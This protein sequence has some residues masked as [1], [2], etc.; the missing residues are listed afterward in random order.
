ME[1]KH[2]MP[3]L[4]FSQ[5]FFVVI[6]CCSLCF[7]LN[8][9]YHNVLLVVFSSDHFIY[10]FLCGAYSLGRALWDLVVKS[11]VAIKWFLCV[12]GGRPQ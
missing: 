7:I 8:Y 6:F 9:V 2:F 12:R 4:N 1:F 3:P 5:K 11:K 10:I